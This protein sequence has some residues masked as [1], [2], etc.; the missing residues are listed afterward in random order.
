MQNLLSVASSPIKDDISSFQNLSAFMLFNCIKDLFPS[1][2]NL[3]WFRLIAAQQSLM[4]PLPHPYSHFP[5]MT[6]H[7][8]Q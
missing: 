8:G 3:T 7:V 4:S 5:I 2:L 1:F 6:T